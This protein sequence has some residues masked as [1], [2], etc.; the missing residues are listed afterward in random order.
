MGVEWRNGERKR[1]FSS[2]EQVVAR[3]IGSLAAVDGD[4][5]IDCFEFLDH[6][7][8]EKSHDAYRGR[9]ADGLFFESAYCIE[10]LHEGASCLGGCFNEFV[11]RF[12]VTIRLA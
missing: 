9:A 12:A 6:F 8:T 3:D 4:S 1:A 2:F 11:E 5:G 10:F 7:D